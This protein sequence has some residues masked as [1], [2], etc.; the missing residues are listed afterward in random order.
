MRDSVDD[1]VDEWL[2]EF[3]ELD[4]VKEQIIVRIAL[5][6]RDIAAGRSTTL[7][8]N[9]LAIWQFKTLLML[10]RQ[11]PPYEL[12]PSRLADLLGLTRGALSARLAGLEE[13]GLLVR[14]HE[15]TDR[16]RVTVRLTEAGN[17]AVMAQVDGEDAAERRL[18]AHMTEREKRTLSGLLRK[19][20]LAIESPAAGG[21]SR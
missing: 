1:K 11:G 8:D 19:L 10:R 2:R 6:S 9:D 14:E 13:R 15:R 18:F 3:P 4:A 5:V 7:D 20:V 16:R 12:N 17:R 21:Q